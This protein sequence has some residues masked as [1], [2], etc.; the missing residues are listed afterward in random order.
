MAIAQGHVLGEWDG[1]VRDGIHKEQFTKEKH[2]RLLEP[3][4]TA[5]AANLYH[6]QKKCKADKLNAGPMRFEGLALSHKRHGHRS[7]VPP[8]LARWKPWRR[9]I[10]EPLLA[11][12]HIAF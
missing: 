10:N 11:C 4:G 5:S 3:N 7:L 6:D 12:T 1:E 8:Q 9:L 2:W